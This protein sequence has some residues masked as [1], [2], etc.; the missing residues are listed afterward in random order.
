LIRTYGQGRSTTIVDRL[1]HHAEK[2]LPLAGALMNGLLAS[3]VA[4]DE[5]AHELHLVKG[6]GGVNLYLSNGAKFAFRPGLDE[7][8]S[9]ASVEI[10]DAPQNGSVV[11]TVS[12]PSDVPNAIAVIEKAL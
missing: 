4:R 5:H 9:Y 1:D 6:A 7:N 3:D 10:L 12:A 11:A 2:L 8:S